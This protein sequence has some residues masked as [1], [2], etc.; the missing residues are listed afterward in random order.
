MMNSMVMHLAEEVAKTIPDRQATVS[1]SLLLMAEGWG[2]IFI[3]I[4]IMM[5][6]ILVLN[7]VFSKKK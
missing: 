4:F 3:V 2:G 1:E 6:C 5:V 7:K